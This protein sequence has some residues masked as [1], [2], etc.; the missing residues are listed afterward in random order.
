MSDD[1]DRP[2]DASSAADHGW[3][4][5]LDRDPT[6][7]AVDWTRVVVPDDISSL[8]ADI[9]ALRRERR[10]A[11][12]RTRLRR[13]LA[14]PGLPSLSAI[15]AVV[16]GVAIAATLISVVG[17]AT[18]SKSPAAAPLAHPNA[19]VGQPRG[20]LPGVALQ[21]ADGTSVDSRALRPS[22]LALIPL[23]CQCVPLLNR[24]ADDAA[25]Q[26]LPL[27]VVA[28]TLHDAEA[29]ALPGRLDQGTTRV[30]YDRSDAL[31]T[32]VAASGLTVVLLDR[33]GTIFSIIRALAPSA[34]SPLT[35]VLHQMLAQNLRVN[36]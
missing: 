35:A 3:S 27:V 16:A 24:L 19:P 25:S 14:R 2:R 8:T 29:G 4:D 22:V 17:S 18:S 28:P 10:H 12:L 7:E 33:D 21:A 13:A 9:R 26:S 15:A 31:A 11:R 23:Q 6:V 34:P 30:L 5:P 32:G 20:L 36:G 1:E